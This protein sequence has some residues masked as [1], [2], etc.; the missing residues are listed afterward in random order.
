METIRNT[1]RS[2]MPTKWSELGELKQNT[3]YANDEG[4]FF[5]IKAI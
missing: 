4:L 5:H 2:I 3:D 1:G